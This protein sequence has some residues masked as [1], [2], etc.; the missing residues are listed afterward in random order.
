MKR[1]FTLLAA[2][3]LLFSCSAAAAE[4]AQTTFTAAAGAP[5]AAEA[6]GAVITLL[7]SANAETLAEAEAKAA[8]ISDSLKNAFL[9][10]G[11]PEENIAV[12]RTG[13]QIDQK[14]QYNKIKEPELVIIGR[15]VEYVMT[16]RVTDIG[17]LQ[18]LL[19]AAVSNGLYSSYE[20]RL[21]SSA[22]EDAYQAALAEAA[23]SALARAEAI[24]K[25]CGFTRTEVLSVKE[26]PCE[27]ADGLS[28]TAQ[29]EVTLAAQK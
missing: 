21:T 24:A 27:S 17:L 4:G 25:A 18:A 10:A 16:V 22:A 20:V 14:Y 2:L 13:V 19:D 1:F 15:S 29:A 11:A 6:D 12:E 26:L 9:G 3:V 7:I 8:S 5:Y 23:K 28:G